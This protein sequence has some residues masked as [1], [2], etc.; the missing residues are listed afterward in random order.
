[1]FASPR[2]P[3][4]SSRRPLGTPG[5][6]IST[7]GRKSVVSSSTPGSTFF[8]PVR[9]SSLPAR[10]TPSRSGQHSTVGEALNYDVQTFGVSL[11]VKVM[12]ALTV[13][14][15]DDQLSA[16]LDQTGWCWMVCL[17]RLLVWKTRQSQVTKLSVCKELQLPPSDFRYFADLVAVNSSGE[18]TTAQSMTLLAATSE[19]TVRYWPS[20][21]QEAS[22]TE[23]SID[24]GGSLCNFVTAIKGGGFVLSSTKNQLVR[25]IPDS[26]GRIYHRVLQQGHGVLSGLGRRVSSLFGILSPALDVTLQCVLW[27]G[28]SGCLYTLTSS[29]VNKWEVDE[30]SERQIFSWESS[31]ILKEHITDAIWGSERDYDVIKQRISIRFLDL[32]LIKKGLVILA[33]AWHLEDSPCLTYYC[34]ITVQ[35][36]GYNMSDDLT[37]EVIRHSP[38]FQSEDEVECRFLC[39]ESSSQAAFLYG[40]DFVFACS[41]GTGRGSLPQEAI[42]F[43]SPGD[44]ILGAGCCMQLPVFFSRNSGLVAITAKENASILPEDV[45]ESIL[46]SVAEGGPQGSV[47]EPSVKMEMVSWED[48]ARLLKNAFLQFSRK[49]SLTA[50]QIVEELFPSAMDLQA[51]VELDR[52]VS[53]IGL[54]LIDDYPASDPRWAESVPDEAAGFSHTSLILLHQLED[55]MKAHS[56]YMDFLNQTGLLTQLGTSTVRDMPMATRF[57]LCEH[58]EKL[59]AAIVLKNYHSKLPELLNDVILKALKKINANIP[60]NLTA[61][62][63]FFRQASQIDLVFEC[64]LEKEEKVLKEK[65]VESVEW[66]QI[67][68]D[69]NNILKDMLQAAVQHRQSILSLYGI[70]EHSEK[71]PEYIPWTASCGPGG[72]RP[73]IMQQHEIVLKR[74]YPQADSA[75]RNILLEQLV[76]LLDCFLDG[77]VSQLKSLD[78]QNAQERYDELEMEYTQKRSELL[79]P[80]L[81]L[82]QYQ[83]AASLAEKY[84]DFDILV[85]LCDQTDNQSRLQR[86]MTKFADQNFSDFL[87]RWYIEK[88]KRGKLLSQPVA[89][90]SQLAGFLQSHEHLSWLHE[91][92]IQDYEKAHLTLQALASLESRY[93]A[94]KK[95]LLGLCKL[96]ALASDMH[97]NALQEAVDGISEQEQFLLYQ[98]TLPKHLLEKK[99]FARE[100]MPVL[101]ASHLIEL[102]VCEENE[103]A[104]EYDFKKA[105]D[106]LDYIHEVGFSILFLFLCKKM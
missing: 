96:A 24:F 73:V 7:A 98:E 39:P 60:D 6:R 21:A 68:V 19:G 77:Y 92:N 83:W 88:G 1:M 71:D 11:P 36:E 34:L 14:E 89:Q 9:R 79:S 20:L 15:D 43:S 64:L 41:T 65:M 48:K 50:Q 4:G 55:K 56:F 74:V 8:S 66:G 10:G 16:K 40:E 67:V 81:T 91:V 62:D 30:T 32:Q 44:G 100:M 31:R 12:E 59:S 26:S 70:G 106:L 52:A 2:T 97:D 49:D 45:E 69:V 104:N 23:L 99:G 53:R 93:F 82:G 35:D 87:F 54:D 17:E 80:L 72:V 105:L 63:V 22:Y 51:D 27:D 94:K 38:S 84:C 102:Y 29:S 86:Y 78:R 37:I 18:T 75:L 57:L 46:S 90:H 58:A 95:T 5:S 103:R 101:S 13:A 42:A 3:T 85:Q 33:A 28:E 76:A 61:A 47:W 25:L